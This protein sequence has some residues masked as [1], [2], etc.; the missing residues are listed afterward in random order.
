MKKTIAGI[1]LVAGISAAMLSGC[2]KEESVPTASENAET[3][4]ESN[5]EAAGSEGENI[6]QEGENPEEQANE[7]PK[8]VIGVLL[9]EDE[10]REG[11]INGDRLLE[12]LTGKDYEVQLFYA[13]G[14]GETQLEQFR[15][16]TESGVEAYIIQPAD[17]YA[18]TE[19]LAEVNEGRSSKLKIVC[20]EDLIMDTDKIGYY[21]TYDLRAMGQQMGKQIVKDFQLDKEEETSEPVTIEFLMGSLDDSGAL[22]YFNGIME[23]LD[24]YLED[25]SLVCPSG[26]LTFQETGILEN[27][28]KT[29]ENKL[30]TLLKDDYDGD[31]PDILVIGDD[32]TACIAQTVLEDAEF[33]PGGEGWPYI[34]GFGCEAEAVRDIAEGR[35]KYSVYLDRGKLAEK[36]VDVLDQYVSGESME[37]DNYQQYDNGVKIIGTYLLNGQLIDVDN[38][39]VLIDNG[40]FKESEVKPLEMVVPSEAEP[41]PTQKA[42]PTENAEETAREDEAEET[43]TSEKN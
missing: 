28:P 27:D 29:A 26:K 6:N 30:K 21:V 36:C 9:P 2:G 12:Q 23:V 4:K 39:Q 7:E 19:T 40:F 16:L 42:E 11:R 8:T 24:P 13:D 5:A 3:E 15:T 17:P 22:F 43:E 34:T 1:L 10:T 38:Y 31:A 14:E 33:I 25:G 37:V 41:T 32:Q 35:I 18:F 20:Y